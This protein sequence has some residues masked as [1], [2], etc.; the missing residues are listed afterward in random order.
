M[1]KQKKTILKEPHN[2]RKTKEK[3]LITSGNIL[4]N[5]RE[6]FLKKVMKFIF[7]NIMKKNDG[8]KYGRDVMA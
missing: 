6:K 7:R 3:T 4:E 5:M 2:L 1:K 8:R